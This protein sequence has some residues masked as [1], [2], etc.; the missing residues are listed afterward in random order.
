MRVRHAH[1]ARRRIAC[2]RAFEVGRGGNIDARGIGWRGIRR[3]RRVGA[4]R[5]GCV[6]IV[7]Q[8]RGCHGRAGQQDR[9]DKDQSDRESDLKRRSASEV[10]WFRFHIK[11]RWAEEA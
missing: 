7:A 5:K 1:H 9:R 4:E 3:N 2:Q 6:R 11:R 10:I 8:R